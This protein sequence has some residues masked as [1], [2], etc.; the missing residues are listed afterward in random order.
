MKYGKILID[1]EHNAKGYKISLAK[2][3]YGIRN[4]CLLANCFIEQPE[5]IYIKRTYMYW[6]DKI[7]GENSRQSD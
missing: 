2:T 1:F 7:Q 4:F 5:H 6:C 3:I